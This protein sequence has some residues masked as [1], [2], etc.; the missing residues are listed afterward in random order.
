MFNFSAKIKI[1]IGLWGL[2]FIAVFWLAW[3]GIVPSGR[4]IYRSDDF[5]GRNYHLT[6]LAPADRV[7]TVE[8]EGRSAIRIKGDPVY[9]NLRPLRRFESARVSIEYRRE[10][11][12][13]ATSAPIVEAGVLV[14]KT[15]W[16]YQTVPLENTILDRLLERGWSVVY[17]DS[18]AFFQSTSTFA[19]VADLLSSPTPTDRVALYNYSLDLPFS[20]PGY[21]PGD[22]IY[23][24]TPDF[25]GAYEYFVYLDDEELWQ[26]ISFVDRNENRDPDP[27][28]VNVYYRR[29]L[30]DSMNLPDDGVTE[31]N[32][33]ASELRRIDLKTGKMPAGVYTI[34]VKA[35]DDIVTKEIASKQVKF[36]INGKFTLTEPENGAM[37]LVT[38]SR[39][40]TFMIT[41]PAARQTIMIGTSTLL[42]LDET[43]HPYDLVLSGITTID[44]KKRGVTIAG[45]GVWGWEFANFFSPKIRTV[46]PGFSAS[47]AGV[48]YIL[49][50]YSPPERKDEWITGRAALDLT[51]AYREKGAYGLMLS[52]PGLKA[53]D[54]VDDA[55]LIRSITVELEGTSLWEKLASLFQS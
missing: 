43:Y 1:R 30:I 45:D 51:G 14:D 29:Q 19:T 3:S 13:L 31:D 11:A 32:G 7:E 8:T 37:R 10:G 15:A 48:E 16:R 55:I 4:V 6:P 24:F 54:A 23:I 18:T 44:L 34:E 25:Q 22:T 39:Q 27:V 36:V 33:Q 5:A 53:D 52:I 12:A 38:D 41:D 40:A 50:N 49:A 2:L 20:L 26:E 42:R 47:A 35:N 9:F 17:S 46:K 21:R 28:T